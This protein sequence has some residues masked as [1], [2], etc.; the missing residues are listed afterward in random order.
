[1][2]VNFSSSGPT[3]MYHVA[4]DALAAIELQLHDAL[5]LNYYYFKS[6]V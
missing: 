4:I 3:E 2:I 1:M 5:L 6:G